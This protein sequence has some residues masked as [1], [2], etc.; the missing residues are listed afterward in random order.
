MK[1]GMRAI[2]TW[3]SIDPSGSPISVSREEF[4]RQAQWLASGSVRV[5]A[6][7]ELLDPGDERPAVALTFDDGFANFATEAAPLLQQHGFAVTLFVVTL[8]VGRDNRWGGRTDSR[9]PLLPLLDWDALGRLREAGVTL[10]AHTRTHPRLTALD[11][12]ALEAELGQAAEELERRL[13]ARPEGLAYPYGD[14]NEQVVGAAAQWY[15][16]ACTTELRPLGPD[17]TRLRLPR[18]D[19]WYLRDAARLESFGS[20]RFRAWLWAR[21]QA[22]RLRGH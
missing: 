14:V 17:E 6:V 9:V 4:R 8:H 11:Q 16:T 15:R 22:R 3:H 5:V 2:L 13:G 18:I 10:G 12:P 19:A 20:R 21:R 1:T 7:E